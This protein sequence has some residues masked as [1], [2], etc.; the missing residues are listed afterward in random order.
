MSGLVVGVVGVVARV[1]EGRVMIARA[2]RALGRERLNI[3][4]LRRER[5]NRS[6]NL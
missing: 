1:R 6:K 4:V 5:C 3:G 2:R